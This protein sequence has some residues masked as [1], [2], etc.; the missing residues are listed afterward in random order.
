MVNCKRWLEGIRSA[1]FLKF[2]VVTMVAI[3]IAPAGYGQYALKAPAGWTG[4]TITLPPGFAADMSFRGVEHIRFAPGMF[5]P[6]APD[7]FSYAFVFELKQKGR[8]DQKT[9]ET[10]FLKYYRGL[11]KAVAGARLPDLDTSEFACQLKQLSQTGDDKSDSYRGTISWLEPF[12]TL[13]NQTLHLEITVWSTPQ[14][15]LLFACV[16]PQSLKT[17]VWTELRKIRSGYRA[18]ATAAD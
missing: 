5:K 6:Q 13:K 16:S 4:E 17:P 9:I 8:P 1:N 7:F 14:N 11:S 10:E 18:A 3:W 12:Q 15:S 2:V